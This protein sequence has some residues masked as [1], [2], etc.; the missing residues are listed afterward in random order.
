MY[1]IWMS[2]QL[3]FGY[4]KINVRELI[5]DIRNLTTTQLDQEA[6][7]AV[8]EFIDE[9]RKVID[10]IVEVLSPFYNMDKDKF[11]QE[12]SEKR[13]K[14]KQSYLKDTNDLE[15]ACKNVQKQLRRLW[16]NDRW[17]SKVPFTRDKLTKLDQFVGV[18]FAHDKLVYDAWN[19]LKEQLNKG[20]DEIYNSI[21][22]KPTS[23]SQTE[24][25]S[26][27][28]IAE[29]DFKELKFGQQE[30]RILSLDLR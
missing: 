13:S 4:A 25:R 3:D 22:K 2:I 1:V 11:Q 30:L 29:N 18:W 17:L 26:F 10:K 19:N 24:L 28:S 23:E 16:G 7:D 15:Y 9:I 8:R 6:K 12:F 5:T 14:F 20:L 27:L 21:G